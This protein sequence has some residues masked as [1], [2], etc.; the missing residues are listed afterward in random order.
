MN[1]TVHEI[2]RWI[3]DGDGISDRPGRP[4]DENNIHACIYK[5]VIRSYLAHTCKGEKER[6]LVTELAVV[7]ASPH[8]IHIGNQCKEYHHEQKR[9]R[10][11]KHACMQL[12]IPFNLS[13]TYCY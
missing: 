6:I 10:E 4:G 2:D 12:K 11:K 9:K 13:F 8:D 5:Y 1:E 7:L 3:D